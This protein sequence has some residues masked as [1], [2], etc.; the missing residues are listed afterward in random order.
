[1]P[2]IIALKG[3]KQPM[4]FA[5]QADGTLLL[6]PNRDKATRWPEE[7]ADMLAMAHNICTLPEF[8]AEVEGAKESAA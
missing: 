2:F 5:Q 1:M 6:T 3:D 7:R 4:Y 8:G